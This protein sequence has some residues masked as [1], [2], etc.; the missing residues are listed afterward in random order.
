[1]AVG[2]KDGAFVRVCVCVT[3]DTGCF[4]KTTE[5]FRLAWGGWGGGIVYKE[6][7]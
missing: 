5:P 4:G 1:M 2:I 3:A 7:H 6:L